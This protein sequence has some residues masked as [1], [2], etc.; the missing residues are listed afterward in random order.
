MRES[1]IAIDAAGTSASLTFEVPADCRA[2]GCSLLLDA[3]APTD[4]EAAVN[5]VPTTVDVAPGSVS[6]AVPPDVSDAWVTFTRTSGE[7]LG[8]RIRTIRLVPTG[9]GLGALG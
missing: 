9:T 5:D 6:V 4:L 8:L 7:P 1:A 2:R 3:D